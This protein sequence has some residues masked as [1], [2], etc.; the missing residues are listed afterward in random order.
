[1]S[2]FRLFTFKKIAVLVVEDH[3][4]A[5]PQ[6][7]FIDAFDPGF[8]QD[9]ARK[10][11]HILIVLKQAHITFMSRPHPADQLAGGMTVRI[12]AFGLGLDLNALQ[13]DQRQ[14][15]LDQFLFVF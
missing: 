5:A 12:R 11:V 9:L 1:M 4:A 3:P 6:I 14:L 8:A 7:R 13:I 10:V 2:V 15:R